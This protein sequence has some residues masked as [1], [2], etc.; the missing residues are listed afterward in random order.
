MQSLDTPQKYE[1]ELQVISVGVCLGAHGSV[2]SVSLYL[3]ALRQMVLLNWKLTVLSSLT[4]PRALGIHL[5]LFSNAGI[6]NRHTG[7]AW[8]FM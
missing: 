2:R 7:H 1:N 8:H 5:S 4:D 3:M 6:T